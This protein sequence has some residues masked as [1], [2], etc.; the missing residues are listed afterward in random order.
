MNTEI[1]LLFDPSGAGFLERLPLE[2]RSSRQ[3]TIDGHTGV[4]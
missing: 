4:N 1:S 2:T 3:N